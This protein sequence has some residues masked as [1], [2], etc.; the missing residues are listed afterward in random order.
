MAP[1]SSQST[2]R[3]RSRL[4]R[5][6]ILMNL[7]IDTKSA[8]SL[9]PPKQPLKLPFSSPITD[10][11]SSPENSSLASFSSGSGDR[12]KPRMVGRL[13]GIE[14]GTSLSKNDFERALYVDLAQPKEQQ[15]TMQWSSSNAATTNNQSHK[16]SGKRK[17]GVS[18]R[19]QRP[20]GLQ[21]VTNFSRNQRDV[22]T[23]TKPRDG[24]N[25]IE[26]QVGHN[27]QPLL[28]L[29][30][31]KQL[32]RAREK[33]KLKAKLA[34]QSNDQ[35]GTGNYTSP[36]SLEPGSGP[37]SGLSPSDGSVVIG[38]RMPY[39]DDSMNAR[40]NNA[41]R[42]LAVQN[43]QAPPTPSILVTPAQ[44]ASESSWPSDSPDSDLQRPRVASSVYS[45]PTPRVLDED[46]PPVPAI[47]ELH[48]IGRNKDAERILTAQNT[49]NM[50]PERPMSADTVFEDDSP[51][52]R[53]VTQHTPTMTSVLSPSLSD[54]NR[55]QSQGW[56]TY[57]LSPLLKRSST[58]STRR[59]GFSPRS[60]PPQS[61]MSLT[62]KDAATRA[63]SEKETSHF[64]PDT[65]E[66]GIYQNPDIWSSLE[67][68]GVESKETLAPTTHDVVTGLVFRNENVESNLVGHGLAAEYY[69]ASAHDLSNEEPYFECIG[70]ICSMT[71]QKRC[72][73]IIKSLQD[74]ENARDEKSTVDMIPASFALF[75]LLAKF[76]DPLMAELEKQKVAEENE[77]AIEDPEN[78]FSDGN[79]KALPTEDTSD[80]ISLDD[81]EVRTRDT[82]VAPGSRSAPSPVV[83][84]ETVQEPPH[85][86]P[87]PREQTPVPMPVPMPAPVPAASPIPPAMTPVQPAPMTQ[88]MPP[89]MPPPMM[90]PVVVYPMPLP[91]QMPVQM[92]APMPPSIPPQPMFQEPV[93]LPPQPR[94]MSPAMVPP[95]P[96][97]TI[98]NDTRELAPREM[99]LQGMV[100][101]GMALGE[102]ATRETTR[103]VSSS[104]DTAA[105]QYRQGER[106]EPIPPPAS[107][108]LPPRRPSPAAIRRGNPTPPPGSFRDLDDD[109][110]SEPPP[111]HTS[112]TSRSSSHLRSNHLQVGNTRAQ[113]PVSPGP[114]S[115]G[116]QNA[117][118]SRGGIPMSEV[119]SFQDER[120]TQRGGLHE[121]QLQDQHHGTFVTVEALRRANENETRRR[122]LQKEDSFW[123]RTGGLWRGRGCMPKKGCFGRGGREGRQRRRWYCVVLI[124]CL[125]VII[126]S[127]ILATCL[128][129]KGDPTPVQS[130]WLNLTGYPPMPT[131]V[132]TVAGPDPAVERSSCI[133]PSQMWTCALPKEQQDGN[134]GYASDRPNFRF[135]ISFRNGSYPNSTTVRS[136]ATNSRRFSFLFDRDDVVPSPT[137]AVPRLADQ[138]FLG[139]TT[140]NVTVPFEGEETPFFITFLSPVD[141][142]D[143]LS[144]EKRDFSD[145]SASATT[146]TP[147]TTSSSPSK[148]SSTASS[149]TTT[150][151]GALANIANLIPAPAMAS[152]G[153]AAAA[154]LYPLPGSQPIKLYD[155][156]KPTEHY[157]FYTY[158]DKS[159]FL[160]SKVAV[161]GDNKLKDSDSEDSNGGSTKDKANVRCTWSQT[162]FLVRI[163]TQPTNVTHMSITA[164]SSNRNNA[165]A[166][167]TTSATTSLATV[168]PTSTSSLSANNFTSPGSFPYPITLT[169]DRHGGLATEKLVYCYSLEQ[170]GYYNLTSPKLEDEDRSSGGTIIQPSPGYV[171][172]AEAVQQGIKENQTEPVDGGT[173]GCEC[174]WRNWI[175]LS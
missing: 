108:P 90:Q 31:L 122:R 13:S 44:E 39:V 160:E 83:E 175:S 71:T 106:E 145:N 75:D 121:G 62:F 124:F 140:D 6:N 64:S 35:K 11:P 112:P 24:D 152:D 79:G 21:V 91:T 94:A 88:P 46:I 114:V 129:H 78:P 52:E 161:T 20:T 150:G 95:P 127:V 117:M 84:R 118:T 151:T 99:S 167:M 166:T 93:P 168:S 128:T 110:D 105:A 8:A 73:E 63:L 76:N 85:A 87:A 43:I 120:D 19:S 9:R 109:S 82:P 104:P 86:M 132:M 81:G 172:L 33:Q 173:S 54:T 38:M 53:Y 144:Q 146:S 4:R 164:S 41:V 77:K 154:T 153:T 3:S 157:G 102:T 126:L 111:Y 60:I 59:T 65:P 23:V 2:D 113:R 50:R 66:E 171:A 58:I 72:A 125:T 159:V 57:L 98:T 16:Q 170:E 12:S 61:A 149:S 143:Y 68:E 51:K 156:G 103:E 67:K 5:K 36:Q 55:H 7:T 70:H 97:E 45:Q 10:E 22:S 27:A 141:T 133:A 56:W 25:G 136:S 49:P 14:S 18:K 92:P 48:S 26:Q 138:I 155:R 174:E 100:P 17:S 80:L 169:V 131:G 123:N 37:M 107:M 15:E 32:V 119:R 134:T 139:N 130:Q 115:P 158:F 40:K 1:T 135:E 42:G 162:R 34:P 163:W 142:S 47:P 29:Q 69:L 74:S 28:D 96:E 165:T 148:T 89:P 147:T 101:R 30:G 116:L 137:P